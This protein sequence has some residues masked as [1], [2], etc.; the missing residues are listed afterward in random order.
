MRQL[1]YAM[2]VSNNHTSIH[3]QWKK[4][5]VKHQKVS[6]IYANDCSSCS[7]KHSTK[8]LQSYGKISAALFKEKHSYAIIDKL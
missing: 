2:L 8:I 1:F 5:L 4:N 3:L 6:K 7:V